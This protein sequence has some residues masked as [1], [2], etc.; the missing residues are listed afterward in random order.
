[1]QTGSEVT[2]LGAAEQDG[3][4]LFAGN[5]GVILLYNGDGSFS[6]HIHSS[7][8]DFAAALSLGADRFLLT[9]EE[10][11]YFYPEETSGGTAP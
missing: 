6:Q 5:G 2:L 7:G 1:L 8:V 4:V 10:G 9:G 11:T 3:K